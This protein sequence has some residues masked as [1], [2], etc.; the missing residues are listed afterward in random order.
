[1]PGFCASM[2]DVFE[3][4]HGLR[5]WRQRLWRLFDETPNLD[6]LLLTKRPHLAARLG[7]WGRRMA[8]LSKCVA[9]TTGASVTTILTVQR[10]PD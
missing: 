1:M 8:R 3:W 5:P 7:P 10:L 4:Q 2:A 6:W 9:L